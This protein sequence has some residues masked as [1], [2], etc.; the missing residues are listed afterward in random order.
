MYATALRGAFSVVLSIL[1]F[2]SCTTAIAA[3]GDVLQHK[4]I[5]LPG[6]QNLGSFGMA[7][8]VQ[9]DGRILLLGAATR[10][11]TQLA[12]TRYNPDGTVDTTYGTLHNG[13]QCTAFRQGDIDVFRSAA[14]LQP[15]GRLVVVTTTNQFSPGNGIQ[16]AVARF[17]IDGSLDASFGNGGE[18]VFPFG[19][20]SA[21]AR[22]L[23]IQPDGRILVGAGT[24]VSSRE[25]FTVFRLDPDGTPDTTYGTN[26]A[27]VGTFDGVMQAGVDLMALQPDGKLVIAGSGNGRFK[28]QR[29]NADGTLDTA[30][31]SSGSTTLTPFDGGDI[32]LQADGSVVVAGDIVNTR[33]INN[34][35]ITAAWVAVARFTPTGVLDA[36]FGNGGI[37]S[38]DIEGAGAGVVVQPDGKITISADTQDI[39][40]TFVLMRFDIDGSPDTSFGTNGV[41]KAPLG[42]RAVAARLALRANGGFVVAGTSTPGSGDQRVMIAAYGPSGAVDTTFNG[43]GFDSRQLGARQA[44]AN[45]AAVQPDGRVLVTGTLTN[46]TEIGGGMFL[47]RF[48]ADGTPDTSFGTGGSTILTFTAIDN[49]DAIALQPDGRIV[50]GGMKAVIDRNGIQIPSLAFARFNTDGTLDTS[51]GNSGVAVFNSGSP[52]PVREFVKAIAVQPDGMI[53]GAGFVGASGGTDGFVARI[54]A[55]GQLDATF[56]AGGFAA[57][58]MSSGSDEFWAMALQPDGRIVLG[59]RAETSPNLSTMA[60][61]RLT[62]AGTLDTTFGSAGIA[63]VDF[64]GANAWAQSLALQPD[65]DIV[66]GGFAHP[67]TNEDYALARLEPDG[68]LDSSFGTGGKVT[69][70][71][72]VDQQVI[73]AVKVLPSGKI[74]AVG[75]D[76]DNTFGIVQYLADGSL[77]TTF[78]SGG[79]TTVRM[80]AFKD[81]AMALAVGADGTLYAAGDASGV[82]GLAIVAGD[83]AIVVR[84]TPAVSLASSGNPSTVG[85]AVT[86]TAV[87]SASAGTPTGTVD[88]LDGANAIAGCSSIGLNGG[89][90]G[91]TTSS[92][93]AGSHSIT[94]QYSGDASYTAAAS[95]ALTQSVQAANPARLANISTRG[96]VLTGDDVLIGGFVIGGSVPKTVVVVAQGPSLAAAGVTNALA[97]P[98]MTLVR[99]SDQAILATNDDWG[100]APNAAAIAASG[101]APGDARESAIMMTLDPGAYTAVVSGVN[102][103]T[104]VGI[105]AVFEV[106]H[107]DVPL[108]NI[109]TRGRV[110]TG[111]DV[112]IGGLIVQGDAPQTVV[113]TA[114]GPSMASAGVAGALANPALTLVRSSDQAV[115]ATNDDWQD[116]PNAAAIGA[117]GFAPADTRES[118]IMVTLPPGAYTAIVSGAGGTTGTGLVGVFAVP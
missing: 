26:G 77:D 58:S 27:F 78:G 101:F 32:A 11:T 61:A 63:R 9:A 56:G 112:L 10:G 49:A 53:V 68:A 79:H 3:P 31:G 97:N 21:I 20:G 83:A 95:S 5:E 6:A 37:E 108:V 90:A 25:V 62:P 110:A 106:D 47:S 17:N 72:D 44:A 38:P 28:V 51:F 1:A 87:V 13:T 102:G 64:D 48:M 19:S 43:T 29:L 35:I 65:G 39:P 4:L 94:A 96:D 116:A 33:I 104:G 18:L 54:T 117:S 57:V 70:D 50:I 114:V 45:A 42:A 86:F 80:N 89:S 40:S 15:D 46:G 12:M 113:I 71:F 88:F 59:G 105:V 24:S 99:S 22:A 111:D 75:H 92:L 91:C 81:V 98:T 74:V 118:A 107:P 36:G 93:A 2:L 67:A 85:R 60:A 66:L 52:N 100:S 109:S 34:T 55:T 76:T 16:V 73:Q 115:I 41:E 103:S 14:A 23:A 82:P 30:W 7:P 8:L 69:T 84:A